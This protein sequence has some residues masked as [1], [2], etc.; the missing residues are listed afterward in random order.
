MSFRLWVTSFC[1]AAISLASISAHAK[2]NQVGP[3]GYHRQFKV[4]N[5]MGRSDSFNNDQSF[6][7]KKSERSKRQERRYNRRNQNTAANND[8]EARTQSEKSA[9]HSRKGRRERERDRLKRRH[10]MRQ[11]AQQESPTTG[12]ND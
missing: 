12:V 5:A 2:I 8:E 7:S 3:Q 10:M 11:G 4:P 1:V 9:E 6:F